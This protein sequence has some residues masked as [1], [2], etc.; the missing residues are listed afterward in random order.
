MKVKAAATKPILLY[1]DECGVC[2]HIAGWVQTS[3]ATS[4][5][6]ADIAV[7]PI[8]ADPAALRLLNPDLDIWDAYA[9]IHM[10]M[11]D[12]SMK[13]G[14]EAVAETLRRLPNTTW[15]A[16]TFALAILGVRPFQLVLDAGYTV[17]A[18]TRPLFGC[19]SC[20]TPDIW[21]RPMARAIRWFRAKTS[22]RH[23]RRPA[24]HFSGL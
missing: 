20:G 5:G 19:E 9:T 16:W 17:L 10:L 4:K 11:P 15:F 14:G 6:E 22:G 24:P 3:A 21:L 8:G 2:R 7:T 18:A 1:N 12:G 23:R 13:V